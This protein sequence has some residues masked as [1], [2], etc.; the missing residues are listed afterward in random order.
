MLCIDNHWKLDL[1]TGI[2]YYNDKTAF[3]IVRDD[4]DAIQSKF[5]SNSVTKATRYVCETLNNNINI[6]LGILHRAIKYK[7]IG[8]DK[9]VIKYFEY[10]NKHEVSGEDKREYLE[11]QYKDFK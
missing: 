11:A 5:E 9:E 1:N 4:L 3:R 2:C 7:N 10:Y 8:N 6:P